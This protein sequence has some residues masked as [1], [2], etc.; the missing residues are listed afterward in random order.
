MLIP[1]FAGMEAS[2]PLRTL[3]VGNRRSNLKRFPQDFR[4]VATEYLAIQPQRRRA[5][6]LDPSAS[7]SSRLGPAAEKTNQ[8]PGNDPPR[9]LAEESLEALK[10]KR[11]IETPEAP[12]VPQSESNRRRGLGQS[13][14]C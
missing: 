10:R 4:G 8:A 9:R 2:Q 7:P 6:C 13:K 3:G 1:R 5:A 11:P 12:N 14:T